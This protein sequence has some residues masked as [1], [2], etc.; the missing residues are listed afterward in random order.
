[1]SEGAEKVIALQS[2]DTLKTIVVDSDIA[3]RFLE[4]LQEI[5]LMITKLVATVN[6]P[7]FFEF[8]LEFGKF[9]SRVLNE[10]VLTLFDSVV[11]RVIY[12]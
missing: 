2:V 5:V 4:F 12:E 11:A 7:Q 10:L 9:Y 8:V 3:K 1:M 6:F